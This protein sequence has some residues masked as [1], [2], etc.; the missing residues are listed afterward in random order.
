M[1]PFS[2]IT[3]TFGYSYSVQNFFPS[4]RDENTTN[5]TSRLL[6]TKLSNEK[7]DQIL[8]SFFESTININRTVFEEDHEICKLIPRDSWSIEPLK[9]MS[10]DEIKINHFRQICR[11]FTL[12]IEKNI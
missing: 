1:F 10:T 3:S 9:Y 11:D 8:S 4:L 6:T 5:F 2:M 7:Y 12:S